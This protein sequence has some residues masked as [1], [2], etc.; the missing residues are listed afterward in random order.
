MSQDSALGRLRVV[1]VEDNPADEFVI[2]ECLAPRF[3]NADLSVYRDGE[4]MMRWIDLIE[5]EYAPCPDMIL[6]DLN[7]PRFTGAQVLDRLR[8]HP[9]CQGVPVIIV[10]SS[11]NPSDRSSAV[12]MGATRYFRKPSEYNEFLKLGDVV[13]EVLSSSN[14]ASAGET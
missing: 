7:L 13:H 6:L 10:T 11:D 12:R 5:S 4:Q 9:R 14:A 1:L 8:A 3:P 2:R